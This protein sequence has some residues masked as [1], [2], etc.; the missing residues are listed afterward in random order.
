MGRRFLL[1]VLSLFAA[2]A[3]AQAQGPGRIVGR[4]LSAEGNRPV[5]GATVVIVGTS[6]GTVTDTAG[7]YT[8][9]NVAAGTR[10]IQ[11]RRIGF[12]SATQSVNV[13]SGQPT[14][15]DFALVVSP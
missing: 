5:G 10:R 3:A 11:A 4:V 12:V 9:A 13:I 1:V 15:S 6:V 8:L 7:R 2:S 14:S